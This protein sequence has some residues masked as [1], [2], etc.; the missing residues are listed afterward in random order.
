MRR[1]KVEVYY[2]SGARRGNESL[3]PCVILQDSNSS[4]ASFSTQRGI[5]F[6]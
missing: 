6:I 5:G 3:A 4:E 1:S 2:C